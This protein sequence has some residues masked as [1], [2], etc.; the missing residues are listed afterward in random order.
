MRIQAHELCEGDTITHVITDENTGE[1]EPSNLGVLTYAYV[2]PTSDMIFETAHVQGK[3]TLPWSTWVDVEGQ[4]AEA[5]MRDAI[6]ALKA[7][8]KDRLA[9]N[10]W[11]YATYNCIIEG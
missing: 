6:A 11:N 4:S 7:A 3:Q 8:G 10:L 1:R 9:R 5:M 2:D